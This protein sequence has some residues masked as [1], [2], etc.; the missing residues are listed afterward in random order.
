MYRVIYKFAYTA[1]YSLLICISRARVSACNS[2]LLQVNV[3]R[4]IAVYCIIVYDAGAVS[5]P[6][7]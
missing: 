2:L 3:A 4:G 6:R 5:N 1:R 7:P